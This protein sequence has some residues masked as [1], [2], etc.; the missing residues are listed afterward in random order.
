LLKAIFPLQGDE[1]EEIPIFTTLMLEKILNLVP[2]ED[3]IFLGINPK[4]SHPRNYIINILSVPPPNVRPSIT[5]SIGSHV[6]GQ[7]DLSKKIKQMTNLNEQLQRKMHEEKEN[8]EKQLSIALTLYEFEGFRNEDPTL[9]QQHARK[10]RIKR[11]ESIPE[12]IL[13]IPKK[14]AKKRKREDEDEDEHTDLKKKGIKDLFIELQLTL[15]TFQN[16]DA[17][18][19]YSKLRTHGSKTKGIRQNYDGKYA[20][21][22]GN[23]TGMHL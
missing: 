12:L 20:R 11:G 6:R 2:E 8:S 15:A 7:D 10:I 3:Y 18:S 4:I 19:N 14:A 17:G 5:H 13:P 23:L 22:R 21:V 1:N 16:S 9:V